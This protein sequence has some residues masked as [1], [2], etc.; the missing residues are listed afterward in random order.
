MGEPDD[1]FEFVLAP[2]AFSPNDEGLNLAPLW[3]LVAPGGSLAISTA[4]GSVLALRLK[5]L[6]GD[7]SMGQ[8]STVVLERAGISLAIATRQI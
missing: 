6:I 5:R 2:R 4:S 7:C 1:A 3:R 8:A